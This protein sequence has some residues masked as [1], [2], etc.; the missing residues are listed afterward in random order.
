MSVLQTI[1]AHL[2][3]FELNLTTVT[4]NGIVSGLQL[5]E[6][7]CDMF[8]TFSGSLFTIIIYICVGLE[9]VW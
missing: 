8:Q 4:L 1:S 3:M 2:W 9:V 5:F 7:L 6:I